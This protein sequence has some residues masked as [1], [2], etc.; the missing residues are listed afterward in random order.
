MLSVGVVC[1]PENDSLKCAL[2]R[3]GLTCSFSVV[4]SM[5]MILERMLAPRVVW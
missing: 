3:K 5:M 2:K 1:R 4:P